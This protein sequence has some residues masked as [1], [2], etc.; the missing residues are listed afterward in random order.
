MVASHDALAARFRRFADVECGETA[1]LYAH[2]ARSI[3]DDDARL[4]LAAHAPPGQ[5]A[6]NLLLGAVH[7]L[8]LRGEPGPL[9]RFYPSLTPAPAPPV[10][11]YPAFVD[12]C[13]AHVGAIED[14]LATRR[15]QTNEVR[16]CAYLFPAF[17]LVAALADH[18]PLALIEIGTSAGLNLMWDRYGY[19]Y[20]GDA[21]YGDRESP[22]QLT[23]MLRGDG[24]PPLPGHV[25]RVARKVGIDPHVID[26][27]DRDEALWLRA[28]VW[29]DHRDRAATL[30]RAVE[31][32]RR[33]PP[34]LVRGDGVALLPDV[35]RAI[36][37]DLAVCVFHTHTLNQFPVEARE[38]LS[39]VLA[40]HGAARDL[41]RVSADWI[42]TTDPELTLTSWR[43]GREAHRLL[44]YTDPHARWLDWRAGAGCPAHALRN[45]R[46]PATHAPTA[47]AA[48]ASAATANATW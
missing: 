40:E 46:A 12:F 6:P 24:R 27:D 21:T 39:A 45:F 37:R 47:D 42:G 35:L 43:S 26:L 30:A 2:L 25:P 31:I 38:R 20:G 5:P 3:A 8:L 7:F 34:E 28:L 18:R 33:D 19:R 15:V 9:A 48:I 14:L 16:R 1:P 22:V 44:A 29:P 32:A 13:M 10:D 17:A 23:C 36:P 41:H 4:D 11:A